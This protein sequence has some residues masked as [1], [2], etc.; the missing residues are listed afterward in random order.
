MIIFRRTGDF[1]W[2]AVL[3]ALA[4]AL[5]FA[6]LGHFSRLEYDDYCTV[7]VG[8]ETDAWEGMVYW[9]NTWAGSYANFFLKSALAPLDTLLP[10]IMP[11]VIIALWL[12][13]LVWLLR[14]A[15]QIDSS[16]RTISMVV[17]GLVAA[18]SINAL[19]SPQAFYWYAASTHYTLPLTLLT[20]YIALAMWAARRWPS[21]PGLVIG[22]ALCFLSAGAAEIFVVFQLV[23]LSLCLL[24]ARVFLRPPL[25][26]RYVRIFALGFCVTSVSLF[27]Y[28]NAPG[29]ANRLQTEAVRDFNLAVLRPTLTDDQQWDLALK[30]APQM[31]RLLFRH[32]GHEQAFAGFVLLMCL[33]LLVM[34]LKYKPQS[35][36]KA[37]KPFQFAALPLWFGLAFQLMYL[38]I[39]WNHSSDQAQFFGR[40]S[41]GYMSVVI[42]NIVFI[43]GFA[44]LLA[45]RRRINAMLEK[46][47]QGLLFVLGI[48]AAV[49]LALFA[50]TQL[51]S[52]HYRA[53]TCLF[54]TALL[55]LSLITWML[56]AGVENRS[57]KKYGYA[58]LFAYGAALISIA[59]IIATA[60]L[61]RGILTPRILAPGGYLLVF[62]GLIWG[63]SLGFLLKSQPLLDDVRLKLL[64]FGCLVIVVTIAAGITL[65]QAA[66]IP[67]FQ[68]FAKE[69]DARHQLI[70]AMRDEGQRDLLVPRLSTAAAGYTAATA[71][72][73]DPRYRCAKH[74]YGVDSIKY[75]DS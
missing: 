8:R 20:M 44:G 50:L 9:Y 67:D 17:A 69:W 41:S 55:F 59:A 57:A 23:F 3:L 25:R 38:P 27:I 12:V 72:P 62:S 39:L 58:G 66:L 60:L 40:F 4:P 30:L 21:W 2:L 1:R 14:E 29:V 70:Y 54:T 22:A 43:V 31:P 26:L 75:D 6:Y 51:R 28:L 32:V 10:Q 73:G 34:L 7:K 63:I 11:A 49:F 68:A 46:R 33:G 24:A 64:K 16:R 35:N 48:M 42:L 19:H 47:K 61:G 36:S 56:A 15:L 45:G 5:V 37:L 74:Y 53:A 13:G 71:L 52:I 18:A 65:G